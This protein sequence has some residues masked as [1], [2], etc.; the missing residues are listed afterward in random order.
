MFRWNDDVRRRVAR[1]IV[2]FLWGRRVGKSWVWLAAGTFRSRRRHGHPGWMS[3]GR[4]DGQEG[5]E[6][7]MGIDCG[8]ERVDE[9]E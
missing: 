7:V 6:Q 2:A 4:G 8:V 5:I 3:G 9:S 1:D